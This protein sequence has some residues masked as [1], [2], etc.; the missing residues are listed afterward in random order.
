MPFYCQNLLCRLFDLPKHQVRVYKPNIGGGFGNKQEMLCEDLCA[1][2]TLKLGRPVQWY[3]TRHEEFT[4]TTSRHATQIHLKVGAKRDGT[5]T[6]MAMHAVANAGAYGNHSTQ[7]VYLTGCY[8]LGLYRCPNQL[9]IGHAVYTNTMPGGA[10]RGYGATQGT[11]AV[12]TL[13]DELAAKLELDPIHLRQRHIITPADKILLGSRSKFH[14]VGSSGVDQALQEVTQTLGPPGAR[15]DPTGRQRGVGYAVSMQASGL[16]KI[17]SAA[18]RLT[19]QPNGHY[20]MRTGSVDVGTG[21]DT[22]LRQIAAEVLNTDIARIDLIAADTHRTPFDGGSYASATLYISGEASRLAAEALKEQ[23]L[24]AA[25]TV[26]HEPADDLFLGATKVQ[27]TQN[28]LALAELAQNPQSPPLTVEREYAADHASLTFAILGVEV[29]VDPD[30]GKVE[31]LRAVHAIDLGK[32]INPRICEGQA[33]G[34]FVMGLGYALTEELVWDDAGEILNPSPRTY[35][36]PLAKDVPPVDVHLIE[37]YDPFGPYGAKG[38]GEIATNCAAPAIANAIANATGVR[39]DTLPMNPERVWQ[40]L[41][42]N[43]P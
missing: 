2:A 12:E 15:P 31:V 19:L 25:A 7:V 43:T 6:A 36:I 39:L 41:N 14:I 3:F 23:L 8:P 13:L 38:L 18:V 5:L 26:L 29:A 9:Y 28:S 27:G 10:F 30:T 32:A 16:A 1:L 21:S 22:T 17:H 33:V 37:T 11:F 40:A 42:P 4:A 34:G 24:A 20:E 35:R